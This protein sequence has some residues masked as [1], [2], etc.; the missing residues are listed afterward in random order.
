MLAHAAPHH[1]PVKV[2]RTVHRLVVHGLRAGSAGQGS[3]PTLRPTTALVCGVMR[4]GT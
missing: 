3:R 2:S 4:T 1:S